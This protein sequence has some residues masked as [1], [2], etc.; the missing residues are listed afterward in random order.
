LISGSRHTSFDDDPWILKLVDFVE[1]ILARDRVRIIGV[2]FGHYVG[3]RAMGMKV[4]RSDNGWEVSVTDVDL[5][6][7]GKEIF[8]KKDLVCNS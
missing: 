6:E 5:T 4:G 3:G 7:K 2:C 1:E 8:G